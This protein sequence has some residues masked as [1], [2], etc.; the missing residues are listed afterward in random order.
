M[1]GVGQPGRLS[2]DG[3]KLKFLFSAG[4]EDAADQTAC[5]FEHFQF[6]GSAVCEVL[7]NVS[8][9]SIVDAFSDLSGAGSETDDDIAAVCR[10]FPADQCS[11]LY[12]F[13]N[14]N[15]S[16]G[17]GHAGDLHDLRQIAGQRVPYH[18][19]MEELLSG[20]QFCVV[21]P[22]VFD[23]AFPLHRLSFLN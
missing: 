21:L 16:S 12:H 5:L 15:G 8:V 18:H 11:L 17:G 10:V 6:F 20:N 7:E 1:I 14:K 9:E 22:I 23:E 4:I 3:A 2:G 19:E 13:V